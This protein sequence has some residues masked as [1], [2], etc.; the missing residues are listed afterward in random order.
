MSCVNCG[1]SICESTRHS[2]QKYAPETTPD[3]SVYHK[4]CI[5][6][7]RPVAIFTGS[8]PISTVCVGCENKH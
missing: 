7:G 1:C 5:H 3:R 4:P 8:Q 6:C 2:R